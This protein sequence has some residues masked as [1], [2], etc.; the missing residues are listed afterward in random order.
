V[1]AESLPSDKLIGQVLANRYQILHRLGEG[2]MGAVYKARHVKVGRSFAVKV[3]HSRLLQDAKVALR[4]DREAELA[5][6][7]RHA[8]VVGV[9]DVGEIDGMRYMVMDFAEGPD[10]ARLLVE[11]PMPPERIIHVVRQLLEGLFHA[12][13]QGLIHRDFKPENVIIERDSHGAELPRIVDFGIAILRDGSDTVDGHG[14]LTTNGLVLGTPHYMAPEQAVADPIDHRI[15]L[16]ALGIVIYEMLSGRLPFDGSGAEVAR[17]NLLLDPPAIKERVPYLE[18][19]PLLEAFARRLMS[20][21]PSARPATANAAREIL[22][23]IHRDRPAAAAALGLSAAMSGHAP[24][25]TQAVAPQDRASAYAEPPAATT[26]IRATP[27]P[28]LP[29]APLVHEAPAPSQLAPP[30][31]HAVPWAPAL[32][33]DRSP[34]SPAPVSPA[35]MSPAVHPAAGFPPPGPMAFSAP[36]GPVPS[37]ALPAGDHETAIQTPLGWPVARTRR[38]TPL[39]IAGVA[40]GTAAIFS[41]LLLTQ[42][43]SKRDQPAVADRELTAAAGSSA[44]TIPTATVPQATDFQATHVAG[45]EPTPA[46][47]KATAEPEATGPEATGPKAAEPNAAEPKTAEPK[48][49]EPKINLKPATKRRPGRDSGT[50][51]PKA[52]D[53]GATDSKPHAAGSGDAKALEGRA[54]DPRPLPPEVPDRKAIDPKP[55]DAAATRAKPLEARPGVAAGITP[56]AVAALYNAV[57]KSINSLPGD[58]S[59]D[60]RTRWRHYKVQ[61]LM[62]APQAERDQAAVQL[63]KI[64]DEAAERRSKLRK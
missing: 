1:S 22:D 48:T 20:K 37:D 25:V 61:D 35:P 45:I 49:A 15:D 39:I 46:E 38:R 42:S 13:E 3:L 19:D 29:V 16:F 9:V 27:S 43:G 21:K 47:P 41:V 50:R 64:R 63:T 18:V 7:L 24:G 31:G 32:G 23:L 6:R 36:R 52:G 5:G 62:L 14:R 56:E 26:R 30:P 34:V 57:L 33:A 17:A 44:P 54:S 53:P 60:L 2:A 12:H 10:L 8:N 55:H 11:A 40:L 59:E 28:S 4:F 58:A 51:E